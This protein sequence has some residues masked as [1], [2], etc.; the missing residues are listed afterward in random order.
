MASFERGRVGMGG[1]GGNGERRRWR[2]YG[3]WG[4]TWRLAGLRRGKGGGFNDGMTTLPSA[5]NELGRRS[6]ARVADNAFWGRSLFWGSVLS[7]TLAENIPPRCLRTPEPRV[8]EIVTSPEVQRKQPFVTMIGRCRKI[9]MASN[10]S[11]RGSEPSS[12]IPHHDCQIS[13][14]NTRPAELS[15]RM[16]PRSVNVARR[17]LTQGGMNQHLRVVYVDH[18]ARCPCVQSFPV[19]TLVLSLEIVRRRSLIVLPVQRLH[20][21]VGAAH[22]ELAD[23][24][25]AVV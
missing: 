16:K 12:S 18:A 9:V 11:M 20:S 7:L 17:V 24:V 22:D 14:R 8:Y 15:F 21:H 4:L 23:R 10:D 3:R 25:D 13:S 19:E 1:L 5:I 2:G 6:S